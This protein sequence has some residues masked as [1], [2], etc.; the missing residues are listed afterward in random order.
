MQKYVKFQ[1]KMTSQKLK[2]K[3]M[4]KQSNV[5]IKIKDGGN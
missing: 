2:Q 3:P 4:K 1:W 5:P